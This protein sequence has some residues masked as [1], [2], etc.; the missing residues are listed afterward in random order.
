MSTSVYAALNGKEIRDIMKRRVCEEIDKIPGLKMALAFHRAQISVAFELKAYPADCP[1]PEGEFGFVVDANA[2]DKEVFNTDEHIENIEE[3]KQKLELLLQEKLRLNELIEKANLILSK[4]EI[5]EEVLIQ[6]SDNG[7]P[8]IL[9]TKND[10]PVP[11]V[12]QSA[13]GMKSE[14]FV[15]PNA[16]TEFKKL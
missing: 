12:Q 6:E 10:M 1:V 2:L 3:F 13:S 15:K 14:V 7:Q 11:V 4:L 5:E 8:D 9:R 16:N